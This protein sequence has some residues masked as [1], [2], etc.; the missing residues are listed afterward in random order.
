MPTINPALVP[1]IAPGNIF[2]AFTEDTTLNIRWLTPEDPV[3]FEAYNRPIAD[4]ALRQLILAKAVDNLELRLGHLA[5]F[6]F[7]IP[8]KLNAGSGELDLPLSWIW[9]MHISIPT[10]WEYL[11]L[12][13]IKRIK[14]ENISNTG[15]VVGTYTGILRL[16]FTAQATGSASETSLFY[17]DYQIDSLSSYQCVKAD[18][19]TSTEE[20]NA[21]DPGEAETIGG[22]AQFRTLDLADSGVAG[23]LNAV[24]PPGI[25]VYNPDGTFANPTIYEMISTAVGDPTSFAGF[26]LIHGT[27]LLV[28]SAYNSIPAMDSNFNSWLASN[29]YPF[30]IGATRTSLHGIIVPTAMFR[31]F[32]ILAPSPDEPTDDISMLNSPV[33]ISSIERVDTLAAELEV[34]F[35]TYSIVDS[36]PETVEF[37]SMTLRRDFIGGR[38][39]PITP[40]TNLLKNI[41]SEADNFLQ[42]FGTGYAV[43][44]SLWGATTNEVESFFDAFLSILDVPPKTLFTKEAAILSSYSISRIPKWVPTQG[45]SAALKGTTA[46]RSTPIYP[47][48]DNRY[49]TEEDQGL[50]DSIDFTTI[51]GFTENVD[52]ENVAYSGGLAH[53]IV[54]LVVNA[55]GTVHNYD[56]DVLPR[57]KV[58]LGRDPVFG[59]EW[60]DGTYFK[61]YNGDAWVTL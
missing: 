35:S 4:V 16:I 40:I 25:P 23:F 32:S 33:W 20:A 48:D 18:V 50:G 34:T 57:L 46:R 29:N 22:W 31:E 54:K 44:S 15:T 41:S 58:L 53:K 21:V 60:F 49:V 61:K 30:R 9:D 28:V 38:V 10:K 2:T 36:S 17:L 52:I 51:T 13:K 1:T 47:S 59:D 14:G 42:G 43:L 26:A 56:D 3:L 39:V 7:L 6:P 55:D 8:P 11:R 27:G 24:P 37:A 45:E 5:I 19:V 12:A